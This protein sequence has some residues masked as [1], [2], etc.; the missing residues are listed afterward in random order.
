MK[1]RVQQFANELQSIYDGKPWYGKSLSEILRSIDVEQALRQQEG[2]HSIMQILLHI[3]VWRRYVLEKLRGNKDY[4][5]QV[6]GESDWIQQPQTAD[7]W[8]NAL[9]ELETIQSQLVLELSAKED[10]FLD[11]LV[12][13]VQPNTSLNV[14]MLLNGLIQHDVYHAGQIALLRNMKL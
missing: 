12:P 4:Y 8:K 11:E 7:D 6:D 10:A 3:I 2:S 13:T 5:V 14:A 1:E 9:E